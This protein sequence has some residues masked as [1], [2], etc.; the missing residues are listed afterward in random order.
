MFS[1]KTFKLLIL[2]CPWCVKNASEQKGKKNYSKIADFKTTRHAR[3]HERD[4]GRAWPSRSHAALWR[5]VL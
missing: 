3:E 5:A 2:T 4:H 1:Q